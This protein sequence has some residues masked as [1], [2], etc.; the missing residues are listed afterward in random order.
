[1]STSDPGSP[2][3]VA[4]LPKGSTWQSG[5]T[6]RAASPTV[7]AARCTASASAGCGAAW[8]ANASTS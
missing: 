6:S 8:R 3:E 1:M 5:H 4:W 7:C 2:M